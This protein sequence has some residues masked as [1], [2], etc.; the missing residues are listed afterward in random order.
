MKSPFEKCAVL[1]LAASACFAQTQAPATVDEM[2]YL[3]FLLMNLASLDHS[4][5][6]V[7]RFEDGIVKQYGLDKQE[8]V[9]IRAAGSELNTLLKQ[10]RQ[11]ARAIVPGPTGLTPADSATL[12][13][14]SEQRERTIETLANRI[15]NSVR[16]ATATRLR[17]PGRVLA[18]R[19]RRTQ[20]Q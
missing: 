6:A 11:S 19:V 9:A 20:G 14:L 13:G 5:D 8:M 17:Q 16:P 3:R 12:A 4:R 1:L 7:Q 15:L 18:T 10:L 2:Q